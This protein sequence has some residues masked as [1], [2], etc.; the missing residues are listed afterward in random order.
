MEVFVQE[1]AGGIEAVL[2]RYRENFIPYTHRPAIDLGAVTAGI[3]VHLAAAG[4]HFVSGKKE[5]VDRLKPGLTVTPHWERDQC[6]SVCRKLN[7]EVSLDALPWVRAA[8]A[9]DAD[10]IGALWAATMEP[11]TD[12]TIRRDI[13]SGSTRIAVIRE[14]VSGK[15][16]SAAA[17][18][19]ESDAA[20]MIIG[21][22]THPDHR[23][24]GYASACVWRLVSDLR[25]RGKSACLIF[26][27]P[28]AG[29][30]YHRLG[31]RDIGMW[32]MLKF[33]R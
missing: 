26:H 5:I 16:V 24:R 27:N 10:E 14:S 4:K 23:R 31:F 28:E 32:K 6:F 12:R 20:A 15:L 1:Q 11:R 8:K 29:T 17:C 18:V 33:Q 7:A 22:A 25:A 19:A 30:I 13:E 21:V 2:M 3:N 9:E